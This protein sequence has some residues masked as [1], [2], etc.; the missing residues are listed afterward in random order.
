MKRTIAIGDIHGCAEEFAELLD[1]L[2]LQAGDRLI[3]L[4]D[5][6]NRGPD[7]RGVLEI[8]RD[9]RVEAI[10]G[11]HEVRVLT[12][13][14]EGRPDILKDYDLETIKQLHNEDWKYL[15]SLPNW[16]HDTSS[17]TVFVHGGFLPD[18]P[19]QQQSVSVITTIQVLD[20][21]GHPAKRS[22]CPEAD[23]WADSWEGPPF[24]VYGHT[25]RPNVYQHSASIGIDTGCVYGGHL[26]AFI[27]EEQSFVQVRARKAY[28]HSKRLP[29]P[30]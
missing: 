3:Q 10:L 11:N 25:P 18:Q 24:V 5:L 20:A 23:N 30:V 2:N 15:E 7:S 13:L 8:A 29:D 12:A 16:I 22:D 28:A 6:I 19:W 17:D 1:A 4:G 21:L 27:L 9:Y 26:T 14:R